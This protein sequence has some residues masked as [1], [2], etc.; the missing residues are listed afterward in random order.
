M[1]C[2]PPVFRT[3]TVPSS[4]RHRNVLG[5]LLAACFAALVLLAILGA[6]I[7]SA[8]LLRIDAATTAVVEQRLA[9]ERLAARVDRLVAITAERYTAMSLSSEPAV[10]ERLSADARATQR[11]Y[12][13]LL[14]DLASRAAGDG[15][16]DRVAAV[17][18]A[19]AV[20]GK[21]V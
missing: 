14:A 13:A 16:R 8:A 6:T 20:F 11:E 18:A 2:G 12:R 15:T 4:K 7:G 1:V 17:G 9:C 19:D 5:R 21:A 10:Q 3:D